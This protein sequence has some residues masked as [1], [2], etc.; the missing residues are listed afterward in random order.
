[1]KRSEWTIFHTPKALRELVAK[2]A[3][4]LERER[5]G[6]RA[7]LAAIPARRPWLWR[8]RRRIQ[9]ELADVQA[10]LDELAVWR[11]AMDG[12]GEDCAFP[13]DYC[14][15]VFFGVGD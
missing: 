13:L 15:L 1:M 8:R 4:A 3:E 9:A 11:A 12:L 14:D 10:E 5:A 2:S 7:E 6:L